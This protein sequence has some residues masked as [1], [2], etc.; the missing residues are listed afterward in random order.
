[1]PLPPGPGSTTL[2]NTLDAADPLADATAK[3]VAAFAKASGMLAADASELGVKHG[4][5]IHSTLS[6]VASVVTLFMQWASVLMIY[7][8]NAITEVRKE[9][10]SVWAEVGG[11]VLGEFLGA[12]VDVSHVAKSTKGAANIDV[13]A[14]LGAALYNQLQAEFGVPKSAN[15]GP[16]E[17]AARI[18]SGYAVNFAVQNAMISTLAD[19]ASFHLLQDFRELG[20]EVAQN[21]GLG[22]LQRM[23]L[24]TLLDNAIRKPYTRELQAQL[25]PSRLSVPEYI[26]AR[27]RGDITDADLHTALQ[28][29][30]FRDQDIAAVINEYTDKLSVSELMT[31]VR[32]QVMTVDDATRILQSQGL[33]AYTAGMRFKAAQLAII[34]DN[35]KAYVDAL[36][37]AVRSRTM[38]T[39]TWSAKMA[40]VPWTADEIQ[41]QK[42]ANGT[43]LEFY[44]KMLTWT[45]VVTAFEQGIVDVN[46]VEAWLV[47]KGY[48]PEDILNMELLL[49]VKFDAFAAAAAKKGATPKPPP[50]AKPAP[51]P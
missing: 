7:F 30:G 22:R 6:I 15:P 21:L 34:N 29:A 12:D 16:G 39:D 44:D 13:S 8:L 25:R 47:S 41:W 48:S 37:V 4:S 10:A 24:G 40:D 20:V 11:A 2:A 19:G 32:Y 43:Y 42:L 26:H 50:P 51:G 14:A 27:N 3:H 31:L 18:F 9:A 45:Q 46:Y 35:V 33:D 1:M 36:N 23:A 38:D 49:A 28:E 5:L 17:K